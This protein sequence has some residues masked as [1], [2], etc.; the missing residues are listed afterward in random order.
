MLPI[1]PNAGKDIHNTNLIIPLSIALSPLLPR[2]QERKR[3]RVSRLASADA[4]G[5][6]ALQPGPK[7]HFLAVQTKTGCTGR[8]D[9]R[10]GRRACD[11]VP[12]PRSRL[13]IAPWAL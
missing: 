6:I 1:R 4:A 11:K 13:S 3:M 9:A 10:V 2:S 7:R 12:V 5:A 8:T